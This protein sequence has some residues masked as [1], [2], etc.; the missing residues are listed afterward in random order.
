MVGY[1]LCRSGMSGS[2]PVVDKPRF[3]ICKSKS[4]SGTSVPLLDTLK[5]AG[6][7]HEDRHTPLR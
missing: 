6:A 4:R 7:R 5:G 1:P 3:R 2:F